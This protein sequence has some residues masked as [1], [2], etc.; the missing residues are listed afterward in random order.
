MKPSHLLSLVAVLGTLVP[1]ATFAAPASGSLIKGS[2]DAVY[3]FGADGKRYVFP[4]AKTYFS[5]YADFSGVQTLT[6]TELASYPLGGNVTYRPGVRLVKI[7]TDPRV[8]A[9]GKNGDLRWIQ[10][11]PVATSL[12]GAD[13][14]KKVDDIPDAFF[15]NYRLGTTVAQ[16]GDFSPSDQTAAATSINTDK[17]IGQPAPTPTPT[18]APTPTPTPTSTVNGVLTI[19]GEAPRPTGTVTVSATP[20]PTQ[21]FQNAR[22]FFNGT[23]AFTCTSLPCTYTQTLPATSP[24]TH[25]LRAE[26]TWTD[27][28]TAI[29]TSSVAV[30]D[31]SSQLNLIHLSA[32]H[33]E[34]R[35]NGTVSFTL[36]VEPA[37]RARKIDL[38]VDGVRLQNGCADTQTCYLNYQ[39]GGTVGTNRLVEAYVLDDVHVTRSVTTSYAIVTN[40]H[41]LLTIETGKSSIRVGETVDVTARA[42][43]DDGIAFINLYRNGLLVNHCTN[44]VCSYTTEAVTSTATLNFSATSQEALGLQSQVAAPA[45]TVQ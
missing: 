21:N 37:I 33:K 2:G 3:Y 39:D 11:E 35:T 14:A 25:P 31:S 41:P 32:D 4:T 44:V 42:T 34:I 20:T 30:A 43:D 18:P 26:F 12:Y 13:W 19:S 23:L 27:G 1:A 22:V 6:D 7:T 40:D 17:N 28:K 9:I 10:T 15:V 38:Y 8:Y 29:A 45:V 24:A 5:W 16:A 36:Y